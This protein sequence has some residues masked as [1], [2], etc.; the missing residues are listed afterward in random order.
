MPRVK[1]LNYLKKVAL[2]FRFERD[3][4]ADGAQVIWRD[5]EHTA[6]HH[7]LDSGLGRTP[8]EAVGIVARKL[9]RERKPRDM[10]P[11]VA[12]AVR[13]ILEATIRHVAKPTRRV[14]LALH[15]ITLAVRHRLTLTLAKLTQHLK[16]NTVIAEFLFHKS[17]VSLISGQSSCKPNAMERAPIAEAPPSFAAFRLQRYKKFPRETKQS[18]FR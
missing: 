18:A 12:D 10:F 15:L 9:A 13:H 7:R 3:I 16:V 2:F 5:A 14:A 11:V 8:E 4:L 17:V 6:G 1:V